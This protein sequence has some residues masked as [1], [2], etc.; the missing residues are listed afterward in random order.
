MNTECF[1]GKII[2]LQIP[3]YE[4]LQFDP[5]RGNKFSFQRSVSEPKPASATGGATAQTPKPHSQ[6]VHRYS[7]IR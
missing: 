3:E 5:A 1:G 2:I 4:N 6:S 7:K